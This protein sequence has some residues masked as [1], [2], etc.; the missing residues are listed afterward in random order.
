MSNPELSLILVT[1]PNRE[2][3]STIAD[4][5]VERHLAACVALLPGIESI[6]RWEGKVERSQEVQLLIKAASSRI[7][8][9]ERCVVALHPYTTPEFVSL[10]ANYV[11]ARYL[12]WVI[13]ESA[14]T[15]STATGSAA[16]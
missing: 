11:N 1:A 8:E 2:V 16:V 14:A 4:A 13:T 9:I 10:T 6:Y 3:A 7:E 15:G 5:L 12:Q